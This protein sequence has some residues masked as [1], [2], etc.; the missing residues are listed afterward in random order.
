MLHTNSR[1]TDQTS[2]HAYLRRVMGE[3]WRNRHQNNVQVLGCVKIVEHPKYH[4]G[5]RLFRGQM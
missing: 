3:V 2:H 1:P 5:V 4:V